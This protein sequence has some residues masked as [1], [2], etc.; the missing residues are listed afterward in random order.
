MA[1]A[2]I[3]AATE[4]ALRNTR[5]LKVR[6]RQIGTSEHASGRSR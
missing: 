6:S 3:F 1:I 5:E 2:S 4:R